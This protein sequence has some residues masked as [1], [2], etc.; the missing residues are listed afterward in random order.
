MVNQARYKNN[1][2]IQFSFGV[3]M[4]S[5]CIQSEKRNV[6]KLSHFWCLVCRQCKPRK[7]G[8]FCL[9]YFGNFFCEDCDKE[10]KNPEFKHEKFYK[11]RETAEIQCFSCGTDLRIERAEGLCLCDKCKLTM[12]ILKEKTKPLRFFR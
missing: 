9:S 1:R 12:G 2:S 3:V 7:N 6:F 5:Y 11:D 8:V 10:R 4:L